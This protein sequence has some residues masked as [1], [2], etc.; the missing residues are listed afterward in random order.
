[1][2]A[3]CPRYSNLLVNV[4][5][6]QQPSLISFNVFF[7]WPIFQ[8]L[9]L[10]LGKLRHLGQWF[11]YQILLVTILNVLPQP[12][13]ISINHQ[14]K[15]WISRYRVFKMIFFPLF[16]CI[17][18]FRPPQAKLAK[19]PHI[20]LVYNFAGYICPNALYFLLWSCDSSTCIPIFILL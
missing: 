12:I 18:W 15:N 17:L 9:C 8:K 16:Y 3:H 13:K 14:L 11:N 1:M 2:I 7:T 6:F 10:F 19:Q 5:I 20:I 4:E